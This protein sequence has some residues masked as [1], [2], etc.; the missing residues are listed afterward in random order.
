MRRIRTNFAK[1]SSVVCAHAE[2]MSYWEIISTIPPSSQMYPPLLSRRERTKRWHAISLFVMRAIS[3]ILARV[4]LL[5]RS[6][7]PARGGSPNT[8][9]ASTLQPSPLTDNGHI[10]VSTTLQV[11]SHPSIFALGDIIDWLEVKQFAKIL[12]GHVPLVT[13]NLVAYLEGKELKKHY[14]GTSELIFITNGK[15]RVL[16]RS[17]V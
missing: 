7:V 10:K 6:Q 11:Q 3:T 2:S 17:L 16:G 4:N 1:T 14:S 12:R 5:C 8:S 15:V 9:Y 13:A